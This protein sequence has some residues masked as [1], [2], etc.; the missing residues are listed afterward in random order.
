MREKEVEST[1]AGGNHHD[2]EREVSL[3]SIIHYPSPDRG[4]KGQREP[5]IISWATAYGRARG[6][7]STFCTWPGCRERTMKFLLRPQASG[8]RPQYSV[9]ATPRLVSPF[10]ASPRSPRSPFTFVV[11]LQH[12]ASGI[13]KC[14]VRR[15]GLFDLR[16]E[17]WAPD[18]AM[19]AAAE[20]RQD[21]AMA[22][23]NDQRQ[24]HSTE[25]RERKQAAGSRQQVIWAT[26]S[27]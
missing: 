17:C 12:T 2:D 14:V 24:R 13:R 6:K 9:G 18:G 26:E 15:S 27:R 7:E 23:I 19:P 25:A 16:P 11:T 5:S 3:L 1:R 20:Q 8:G 21:E 22:M 10:T 4:R